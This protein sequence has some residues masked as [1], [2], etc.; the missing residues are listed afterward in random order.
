M[1][2]NQSLI[3]KI[4][5]NSELHHILLADANEA[6]NLLGVSVDEVKEI[7]SFFESSEV[8]SYTNK[9]QAALL[10]THFKGSADF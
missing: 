9:L 8:S 7:R 10:D 3:G 4:A 6:S 2:L 1:A 5:L